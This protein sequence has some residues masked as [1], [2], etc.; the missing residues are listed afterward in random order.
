MLTESGL[1]DCRKTVEEV[2]MNNELITT[3]KRL[4]DLDSSDKHYERRVD[5]MNRI[6]DDLYEKIDDAQSRLDE[7]N[8]E[9]SMAEKATMTKQSIFE[10][11]DG[12]SKYYDIMTPE[13]KISFTGHDFLY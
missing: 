9:I 6:L 12:F 13:E 2:P 11:L 8:K 7:I 10:M 1:Q 3:E 5:S 4:T